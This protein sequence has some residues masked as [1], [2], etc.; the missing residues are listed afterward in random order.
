MQRFCLFLTKQNEINGYFLHNLYI[1]QKKNI[2][3]THPDSIW[4]IL[5]SCEIHFLAKLTPHAKNLK[6]T[7]KLKKTQETDV[8]LLPTSAL[9]AVDERRDPWRLDRYFHSVSPV[10]L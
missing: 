4:R 7:K 5:L 8:C 2:Y 6:N 3:P 10:E 1:S 9:T